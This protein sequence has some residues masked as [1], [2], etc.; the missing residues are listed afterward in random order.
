VA[1]FSA[2]IEHISKTSGIFFK[3]DFEKAF[4]KVKWPFLLKILERK[5][6]LLFLTI[7]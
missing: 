3:I 5:G 6:F 1:T 2:A 4:D 7:G